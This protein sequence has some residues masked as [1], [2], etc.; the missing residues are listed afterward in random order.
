RV[1]GLYWPE[2]VERITGVPARYIAQA[3]HLLGEAATAMVLT[4]R[5]PEQQSH[6]IANTLAFINL[7][8]AL[9]KVGRPFCGYGCLTGQGNGQGGREHGQ[10]ADQLPGY[11][12]LDDER[13]RAEVAE[14]WDVDPDSLP[15][16]GLSACELLGSMGG[17]VRGLLVMASNLVV[18]APDAQAVAERIGKLDLLVVA[19]PFL[20]ETAKCADVVLPITQWAEEEGTMTNLEGRVLLRRRAKEPPPG[21]GTDIQILKVLADRLGQGAHFSSG[22]AETF[23]EFR[24]ATA[25]G[26][27]D[28]AG[29]TY[30]RIAAEQGVFWPCKSESDPG[31]PRLFLDRFAT[32]DGRARFH[33]VEHRVS[34]EEPDHFF[35]Y[36]L[37]TGRVLLHYQSGAQTRRV[38]ELQAA[39]PEAFAEIHHDT[40]R[41]LGISAGDRVRLVTR[42]GEA[43][44]KARVTRDIRMD[45][46]FVPFHWGGEGSANLLTNAALDPVS[47]IPEFKV[48]AVRIEKIMNMTADAVPEKSLSLVRH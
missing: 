29:I 35:P 13:H 7:A 10:K 42:R 26:A 28:Y 39:E 32:E 17:A 18:S 33:A 23:A 5:G 38:P 20:S 47:R 8:L 43:E 19:D 9:G 16:P 34:A 44:F 36:V 24:R 15:R 21:V 30:E 27:A 45:T 25:G 11:R 22:A 6:G 1:C 37:T 31:T 4:V 2:R 48:C 41:T 14:V 3:A 40:A 46:V 12:R